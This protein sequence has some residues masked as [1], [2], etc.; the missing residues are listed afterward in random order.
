MP[1]TIREHRTRLA[2]TAM[3][4]GSPLREA[5]RAYV[6]R[7]VELL[8]TRCDERPAEPFGLREWVRRDP[9]SF[10]LQDRMEPYWSHC[11]RS[12][13]T[14]LRSLNEYT[15]L[16]RAMG[17][18]GAAAAHM[19]AVVGTG[20]G[21]IRVTSERITDTLLTKVIHL[22]GRLA[23]DD[24]VFQS[25]FTALEYELGRTEV[26]FTVVAPLF[27]LRAAAVPLP[28]TPDAETDRLTDSEIAFCL[29]MNLLPPLGTH[30]GIAL[31]RGFEHGVRTR[32]SLPKRVG[33]G[34][35]PDD[36]KQ[37]SAA[38]QRVADFVEQV[39]QALR[40]FK[41]GRISVPGVLRYTNQWPLD[42][43]RGASHPTLGPG[44]WSNEY[45]MSDEECRGFGAFWPVFVRAAARNA[46]TAFRRFSYAFDRSRPDDRLVDL[47]IAAE[48]LFLTD[49]GA[50]EDRGEL[51]YRL[52]LRAAFFIETP[53]YSKREVFEHM[54]RAY[55]VR[56]SIVHGGLVK[57]AQL[58]SPKGAQVS[59]DDFVG[60]TE[61]LMRLGLRKAA[62][63]ADQSGRLIIDWDA[64]IVGRLT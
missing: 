39:L 35:F 26:T 48:S 14:A 34:D 38:M 33:S 42:G 5:A 50:T 21:G 10:A 3:S 51:K 40:T 25:V 41:P 49:A 6:R 64:M 28:L 59:L 54:R 57:P 27:G 2:A 24:E 16:V 9:D 60:I 44:T 61:H 47:M 4:D 23:F 55:L 53:D 52:A 56:S 19:D 63:A 7:A 13:E 15:E 36:G 22:V 43:F 17:R 37:A 20:F 58:R 32:F 12:C 45:L 30:H 1:L 31:V 11:L 46:A 29:S 18:D 8:A 62:E